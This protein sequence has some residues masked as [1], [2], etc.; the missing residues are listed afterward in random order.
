M[1]LGRN[2]PTAWK[3]GYSFWSQGDQ[4]KRSGEIQKREKGEDG[5][6]E[7]NIDTRGRCFRGLT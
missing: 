5:K 7:L 1:D 3:G 4:G 2:E 6:G